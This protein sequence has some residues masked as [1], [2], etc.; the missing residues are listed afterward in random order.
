MASPVADSYSSASGAGIYGGR[1]STP[2][3]LSGISQ[4]TWGSL[5]N[6]TLSASGV[7]W[8][9]T[10]PGG[11]G[12]Y[13]T[14]VTAWGGGILN[15]VG[16]YYD[17]AFHSGTF[18]VIW[19]GGHGDY[20]G[21]EVYAYGPMESDS[22]VWHRLT[23]PTIPAANNTARIDTNKPVSRHTYDHI[24]FIPSQNKMLSMHTAGMYSNGYSALTADTFDFSN[25]TWTAADS[26][27]TA[28]I[29]GSGGYDAQGDFNPV[30]GKAWLRMV[31]NST[32]LL[33]Y[34]IGTESWTNYDT[35]NINYSSNGKAGICPTKNVLVALGSSGQ[36][37]VNDLAN[38]TAAIYTPTTSGT[39]PSAGKY[40]L[41]WDSI[42]S[43]FVSWD[44]SGTT[45]YFLSVPADPA[46]GTWV[47]TT[48]SGSGGVTPANGVTY[49]TYGRF[50]FCA[51]LGG[52]VLMPTASNPICFYKV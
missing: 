47:W 19:G 10:N 9:G 44:Q 14:I 8:A 46:S 23:D 28:A 27:Y 38:P 20:A 7:G 5:P 32:K 15:T 17:A 11:S 51:S 49:G 31:G 26:G 37:L 48:A 43:R 39:G 41:D 42:N 24:Q 12:G 40:T 22:A 21:N 50:R 18:M 52:I 29:G 1:F 45:V 13:Q 35:N 16:C 4:G 3:W 36:L 33:S 30:T 34:D 25:N 6:S 2:A